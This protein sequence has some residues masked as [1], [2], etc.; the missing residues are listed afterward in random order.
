MKCRD[1]VYILKVEPTRVANELDENVRIKW[2]GE[3]QRFLV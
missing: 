1:S 2:S 3:T